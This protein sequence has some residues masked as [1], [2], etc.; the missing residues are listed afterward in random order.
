[1]INDRDAILFPEK[2]NG[3]F[4]MLHRPL[5][6]CGNGYKTEF[7]AIWISMADDLL[8]FKESKLLAKP[9]NWWEHKIGGNTPPIRTDVGWLTLYHA[10]GRDNYYRLGAMLLD[11][12][13][14][15]KVR[16]RTK[17]FIFQPKEDYEI[18]GCYFG[19]GV[20]F[21]CGKVNL[22]D[23]AILGQGWVD[24]YDWDDLEQIASNWLNVD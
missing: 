24:G 9:E 10:V 14:P 2:I 12:E 13:E 11:L 4:V 20:V 23:F 19:G 17:D 15:T 3:K 6:W 1:M 18:N 16:Y 5:E 22:Y 7:P 8:G 21:P